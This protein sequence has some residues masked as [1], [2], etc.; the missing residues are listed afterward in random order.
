MTVGGAK[1]STGDFMVG[2]SDGLV[3]VRRD[4]AETTAAAALERAAAEVEVLRKLDEGASTLSIY[5]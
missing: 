5:G 1:V 4:E 3:T 2:D